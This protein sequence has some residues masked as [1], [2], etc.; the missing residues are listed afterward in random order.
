VSRFPTH[1]SLLC[2]L[3]GT[4]AQLLA[5]L[6]AMLILAL[7]NMFYPGSNRGA[8]YS[9][10]VVLYALTAGVAGFV[11]AATYAHFSGGASGRWAWNLVLAACLYPVPF[12]AVF[13][14][15]NTIAIAYDSTAALPFGTIMIVRC[16][17]LAAPLPLPKRWLSLGVW[18]GLGSVRAA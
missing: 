18:P 5:L 6:L 7:M 12:F 13:C 14:V 16:A 8:I 4:G 15:L 1:G 2:A 9:A 17:C 10:A 11:S 3:L